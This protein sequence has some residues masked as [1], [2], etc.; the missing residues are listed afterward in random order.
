MTTSAAE[1]VR[2]IAS[3]AG[4]RMPQET[5]A[6]EWRVLLEDGLGIR[7]SSPDGRT[8]VMHAPVGAAP[9][10][11]DERSIARIGAA[12]AAVARA[13]RSVL[14]I[15]EG[16]LELHRRLPEAELADAGKLVKAAEGFLNEEA[17]WRERLSAGEASSSG[18]APSPFSIS[19]DA[20]EWLAGNFRI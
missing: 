14:S 15:T 13:H 4:W 12:A 16:R 3:A 19:G 6:G 5:A 11:E 2:T 8:L 20:F 7:F 17:W 10:P 9:E 18:P 1:A